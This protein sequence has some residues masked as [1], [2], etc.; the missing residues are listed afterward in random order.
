M[1]GEPPSK[2]VNYV[3]NRVDNTAGYISCPDGG[4]V[5]FAVNRADTSLDVTLNSKGIPEFSAELEIEADVNAVQCPIDISQPAVIDELEKD[6]EDKYNINISKHIGL[7]RALWIRCFG[8]GEVLHRKYPDVW[9]NTGII[10]EK[11][12]KR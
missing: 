9:K 6:I 10:G 2:A 4:I 12:L 3:L 1:A 11:A 5:G 7:V 8:F